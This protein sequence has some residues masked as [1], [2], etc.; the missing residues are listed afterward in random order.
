MEHHRYEKWLFKLRNQIILQ[1]GVDKN[2]VMVTKKSQLCR[3][4][5]AINAKCK[6]CNW[7]SKWVGKNVKRAI[8]LVFYANV[9]LCT[10]GTNE[11][12]NTWKLQQ[13]LHSIDN[14]LME[15]VGYLVT[16]PNLEFRK[17]SF[18]IMHLHSYNFF[19][20]GVFDETFSNK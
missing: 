15:P 11:T 2:V 14:D 5:C 7:S 20:F 4:W 18:H 12:K 3:P 6:C 16:V 1:M 17:K 10:L 19:S 8:R 13:S 9:F